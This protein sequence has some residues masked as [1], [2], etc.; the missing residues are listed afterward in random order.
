MADAFDVIVVGAGPGGYVAAIRAAQLGMTV[1]CVDKRDAPGGTCLNIGCIPSKALLQS[2]ERFAA[3]QHELAAHGVRV[4]DVTLDLKT[5]LARKDKVVSDNTHGVEFLF[6]KNKVEYVKGTARL[7]ARDRVAVALNAGGR[8]ELAAKKA[9]ILATGSD[10][11]SLPGIAI[12]ERRIVSSTGALA[13]SAVPKHLVVVGGGYIGLE[14]GSVWRR[15]GAEV[16]VVEFLDRITPGMDAELSAALQRSLERQGF[17]FRLATKVAEAKSGK[18]GVTLALEP[19]KGGARENLDADIVLVA[20]GRVPHTAEL[21]LKE[22]GVALDE[23]GRIKVDG[24]FATNVAGLYAIGDAITGPMLAHKASE[25]G[26]VLAEMLAGSKPVLDYD[27]IPAVIYTWPEV[28]TVGRTEEQLKAAGVTY[29]TGKF[30][31]SANPRARANGFTEGFVKILADARSDRVLGVHIIGPDAGTLIAE[32]ALAMEFAASAEDIARTV[33][34]HP[35]LEEAV[36]EAALA[37]D[38]HPIH[39]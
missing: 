23:K 10:S 7:G 25:E 6:R 17:K 14:M 13:L 18:D 19:A 26:V 15:L 30:P 34:A 1:A 4:A 20:V 9:I 11:A 32:A 12:D 31:F 33:H 37:V 35:T 3:A 38:G 24:R 2:S 27:A 22:I 39:I 29:K 5:M 21:G 28:A 16:T 36:K 8:R